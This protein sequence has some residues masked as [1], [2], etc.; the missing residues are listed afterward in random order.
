MNMPLESAA[1]FDRIQ[2]SLVA[3]VLLL[4][5]ALRGQAAET[6]PVFT[7]D[8][9]GPAALQAWSGAGALEAGHG[10]QTLKLERKNAGGPSAM[11]TV[12]LPVE[13]LRGTRVRGT[14]QVRAEN[15]SQKPNSWNGIKFM[16]VVKTPAGTQYPQAELD[17]G[18]FDWRRAGVMT[19]IPADAQSVLLVAGLEKVT[20]KVWFDDLRISLINPATPRAF[21]P[22]AQPYQSHSLGRLRGAM[23]APNATEEDL[24]VFGQEWKANLIRWQLVRYSPP[25]QPSS[26]T[27]YE[28][29]LEGELAKFDRLLPVCRQYGL[30]VALD[31]HSPPGG[32]ATVSGYVGSD[33]RLFTDP[34]AQELFVTVWRKM[35]ARY[36]GN[37]VIWGFD[38]ANEPVETYVEEG[39][40]DW[41]GLAER[42]GRAVL[43]VDPQRTLIIEAPPWG[44]P[45]SLATFEPLNLPNVVYSAHMYVPMAFTH[46]TVFSPQS[47]PQ[48]YPGVIE[49]RQWDQAALEQALQPV[50]DF[51]ARYQV[52]VYI[53]EFSAIRWAPGDSACRYLRDV[54]ELFEKHGWD[55]SYHAFREWQGWSAEHDGVREHTQRAP[56]VTDRGQ[57]LRDWFARNQKPHFQ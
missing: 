55:W 22:P 38:L 53:G 28:A 34:K 42:A 40:D 52:P 56:S 1:K 43:E 15:V 32:K 39:C 27:D 49:G 7:S 10:G 6:P 41:H 23:V 16:L 30:M 13:M 3:S 54:I 35:A 20:G 45:E 37:P 25:G 8:F 11:A 36:K 33:D 31:L 2:T 21:V 14:V 24:R 18:S 4:G 9:E 50:I 17:T 26:L 47:P 51:Q 5:L 12:S 44:G 46:Q 57:L 19:R 29:W 48:S